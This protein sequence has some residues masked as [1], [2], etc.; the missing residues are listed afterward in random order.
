MKQLMA[1]VLFGAMV[2]AVPAWAGEREMMP[3]GLSG[4]KVDDAGV[5]EAAA[6]A[7]KAQAEVLKKEGQPGELT[8]VAI[9]KARTQ[10]VA[11]TN[12]H[13]LLKVR[14]GDQ[15]KMAAVV[16]WKKLSGESELTS[17]TWKDAPKKPAPEGKKP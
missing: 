14:M 11:G 17:W 10:V 8:L 7:V 5:K 2:L 9:V 16:V 6:F 15:E 4:A 13:L 3:G 1:V 12:Y